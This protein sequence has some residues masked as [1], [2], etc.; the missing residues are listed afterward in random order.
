M[1]VALPDRISGP[2]LDLS[3]PS[4]SDD[5][6]LQIVNN[7]TGKSLTL[8]MGAS[9]DGD[10]LTIDFARKTIIDQTGA[11]R[12]ALIG[13]ERDLFDDIVRDAFLLG[14]DNDLSIRAQEV[15][16]LSVSGPRSPGTLADDSSYG[17]VAWATPSNA[18]ASD[19]AYATAS[20]AAAPGTKSHYLKAT[21]FG[22]SLP[23]ST[24]NGIRVD[25]EQVSSSL[26]SV[27]DSRVR[28]VKGGTIGSTERGNLQNWPADDAYRSYGSFVDLWGL[29]WTHTDINNSG[30]GAAIAVERN[31]APGFGGYGGA[32]HIRIAVWY[33]VTPS[34]SAH[35][36]EAT[37]RWREA[38]A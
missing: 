10:D 19:N 1:T 31:S 3:L 8:D 5:H 37:W 4:F 23:S 38:F 21:N 2:V 9:W 20:I 25:V 12:S 16:T 17:T 26:P 30:F 22:F 7:T 13:T 14:G 24:I 11:D 33:T 6:D 32:D 28:I 27:R 36:G 29:S 18:G 34:P 15:A 35:G